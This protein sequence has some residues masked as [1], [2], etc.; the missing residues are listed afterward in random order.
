MGRLTKVMFVGAAFAVALSAGARAENTKAPHQIAQACDP[1]F[2][3]KYSGLLR[4]IHVPQDR[5]QYGSCRDY[6]RWTGSS[7]KGHHNL[8]R[9]AYWTYSAPYWYIW[10]RRGSVGQ[11]RARRLGA[12]GDPS[13]RGKYGNLVRRPHIPQDRR[14]YGSCRDYGRWSGSSYRGHR[15]LP[16]GFWVYSYPYWLI[17]ATRQR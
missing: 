16:R 7:Y 12:C 1:S 13:F 11:P 3:G 5:R 8:P 15:N 9:S 14:Q 4:R 2:R 6:G 17:Y 10:A